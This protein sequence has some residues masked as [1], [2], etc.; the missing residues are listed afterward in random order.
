MKRKENL[1]LY[2][3]YALTSFINKIG[4]YKRRRLAD[5]FCAMKKIS[6]HSE[7]EKDSKKIFYKIGLATLM[8]VMQKINFRLKGQ[9]YKRVVYVPKSIKGRNIK[10]VKKKTKKKFPRKRKGRS[11]RNI[12]PTLFN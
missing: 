2:Y 12:T 5:S 4:V 8:V 11:K 10:P 1:Q 9:A 6:R 3:D 7:F